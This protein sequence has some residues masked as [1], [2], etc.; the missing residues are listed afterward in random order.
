MSVAAAGKCKYGKQVLAAI[1]LTASG[2]V[3]KYKMKEIFTRKY[4]S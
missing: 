1:Q 3:Q 2:K 4:K